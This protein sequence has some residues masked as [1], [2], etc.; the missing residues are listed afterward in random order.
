MSY[1]EIT[2]YEGFL[3]YKYDPAY[4]ANPYQVYNKDN[5]SVSMFLATKADAEQQIRSFKPRPPGAHG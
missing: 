1:P 2:E 4:Q 3:I 5:Q